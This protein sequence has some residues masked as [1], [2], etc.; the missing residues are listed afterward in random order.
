M[1][2]YVQ[3]YPGLSLDE[4]HD[5]IRLLTLLPGGHDDPIHCS[6]RNVR[7]NDI[8]GADALS[9][10]WGEPPAAY[11]T[12]IND[13]P[14]AV[15]ENLY[16]ALKALR[17]PD[18]ER[19]LWIDAVCIDQSN[20]MERNHQVQQMAQ[21]FGSAKSVIVW[22]GMETDDIRMAFS[23]FSEAYL[24]GASNRK[25]MAKDNR[26]TAIIQFCQHPYWKRVWIVQEICLGSNIVVV[27]GKLR[28]PWQYITELR[29]VRKHVWPQYQSQEEREFMRSLPARIDHQKELHSSQSCVLWTLMETFQDSLCQEFH[30]K[31][32]G[33]IGLSTDCGAGGLVVDYAKSEAD[34]HRELILLYQKQLGEGS[35]VKNAPQLLSLS[36]FIQRLLPTVT[37]TL[38]P[39][40]TPLVAEPLRILADQLHHTSI[41]SGSEREQPLL[42]I[43]ATGCYRI[44]E[45]PIEFERQIA[46][47]SIVGEFLEG[48]APYSHIGHWREQFDS[49]LRDVETFDNASAISHS[50]MGSSTG[51]DPIEKF[52]GEETTTSPTQRD[53]PKLFRARA[54]EAPRGDDSHDVFGIAPAG[55]RHGDT[56]LTFLG[57]DI[58][59][60]FR[61]VV[62]G[63]LRG[64][65]I[66]HKLGNLSP[67][68]SSF[69]RLYGQAL[70][71]RRDEKSGGGREEHRLRSDKSI[72]S[73]LPLGADEW[74][75]TVPAWKTRMFIDVPTLRRVTIP[76]D[77]KD[78]AGFARPILDL[79]PSGEAS[80]STDMS[81]SAVRGRALDLTEI[82]KNPDAWL[83][84]LGPPYATI[85]NPASLGY[86]CCML[87]IVFLLKP[88]RDVREHSAINFVTDTEH[89][90]EDPHGHER[91]KL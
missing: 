15:R 28:M 90:P 52:N 54:G 76:K 65:P 4:P 23:F 69:G 68:Q 86:L 3:P 12:W 48:H 64:G 36:A 17:L 70:V 41:A 45:F 85:E 19:L 53:G 18:S 33:F 58:T 87:Q 66:I 29:K 16:H 72:E 91:I 80:K 89:I 57:S 9:Y 83:H 84:T 20:L 63:D 75:Y 25:A 44:V 50:P 7:R 46:D 88:I 14:F 2:A 62:V 42:S 79:M 32:Y 55:C 34:L 78:E 67:A 38:R 56:V 74:T 10:T 73:S 27:C 60:L 1:S 37:I 24:R 39:D 71:L 81:A 61:Q 31:V 35:P 40:S 11:E 5:E 49:R 43:P 30:D 51:I 26:W 13:R 77:S 6:L 22:L 47:L 8:A 21:I 82:R 59:L